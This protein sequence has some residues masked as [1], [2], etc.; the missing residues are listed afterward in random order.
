[1]V[2][3]YTVDLFGIFNS[4]NILAERLREE[5]LVKTKTLVYFRVKPLV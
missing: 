3:I 2:D 5:D 4:C 1:M